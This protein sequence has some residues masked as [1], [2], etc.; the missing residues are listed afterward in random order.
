MRG[1][2]VLF[3]YDRFRINYAFFPICSVYPSSFTLYSKRRK[4]ILPLKKINPLYD[5]KG[6]SEEVSGTRTHSWNFRMKR[7]T[8]HSYVNE[9]PLTRI[10]SLFI[11]A[12]KR[13]LYILMFK[14][15]CLLVTLLFCL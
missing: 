6:A 7:N 3:F 5:E 15:V 2:K 9:S 1:P 10:K 13:K 12:H 11:I 14:W 8:F 4:F